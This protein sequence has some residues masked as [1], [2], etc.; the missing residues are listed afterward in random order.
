MA[1]WVE[2]ARISLSS[3]A[4]LVCHSLL[5]LCF[6]NGHLGSSARWDSLQLRHLKLWGH[7]SP[8]FVSNLGGLVLKLALQHHAMSLW[9]SSLCGPLHFWHFA[10]CERH[11][12]VVWSHFQ[13]FLH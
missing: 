1:E 3:C 11:A 2:L 13:Q 9:C 12:N 7:G 8:A 10:L 4:F 6:Q 5:N